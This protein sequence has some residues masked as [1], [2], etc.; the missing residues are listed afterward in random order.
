MKNI[1]KMMTMGFVLLIV[2]LSKPVMAMGVG[3]FADVLDYSVVIGDSMYTLDFVNNPTNANQISD[4]VAKN[5]GDIFIKTDDSGWIKNSDGTKVNKEYVDISTIKYNNGQVIGDT[6]TSSVGKID[7]ISTKLTKTAANK[8]TFKYKILDKA[9]KDITGTVPAY[10]MMMKNFWIN[11]TCGSIILDPLTGTGTIT[12]DFS[13]T[14]QFVTIDLLASNGAYAKSTLSL[15]DAKAEDVLGISDISIVAPDV[16]TI[17]YKIQNNAN[18][19][20][21]G[22]NTTTFQYKVKNIYGYDITKKIP[23]SQIEAIA[24]VSSTVILDPKTSIGTITYNSAADVNK[25]INILL[26]DKLTGV[27]SDSVLF[28]SE[29]AVESPKV[30]KITITSDKM[31]IAPP[32]MGI[33]YTT[34][35]VF[36]Q[37]GFDITDSPLSDSVTFKSEAGTIVSKGGI[38]TMTANKG[39]NF[40]TLK[41]AVITGSDSITGT[42]T[43]A[44]LNLK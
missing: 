11:S 29:A 13:D 9:G 23:A 17:P 5:K 19:T 3:S 10:D 16:M 40:S 38:I 34:Y 36:N 33:G 27:K 26:K 12:Y 28:T 4:L 20:K 30:S 22:P 21:T 41:S 2:T 39:T 1:K 7:L 6:L 37:Y 14:D 42:S 8:A 43:S 35:K 15:G 31:E 18:L 32:S 25:T 44:T 24:S